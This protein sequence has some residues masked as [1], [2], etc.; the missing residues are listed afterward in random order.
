M[1]DMEQSE[2]DFAHEALVEAIENQIAEGHPREAGLVMMALTSQ[3]LDH[4]DA[5]S[6]MAQLL[7]RHI[8][9]SADKT[10]PFD[11]NAYAGDLLA[12]SKKG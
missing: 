2:D 3:G 1:N 11:V 5:L 9:A 12:L 8:A 7:A 10:A 6:Q 4:D